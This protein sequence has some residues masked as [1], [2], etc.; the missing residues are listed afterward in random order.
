MDIYLCSR[1]SRREEM[2]EVRSTLR[3]L[4][5]RVTS[6]WLDTEWPHTEDGS[7]DAPEELRTVY[8]EQD[9]KDILLSDAL[10]AFT[11]GPRS[12][13]RGGRHVEFGLALAWRRRVYIVGPRE[14]VFH[15]MPGVQQFDTLEE[16]LKVLR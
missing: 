11:D 12:S 13:G 2:R 14:N 3:E 10:I 6:R 5:H 7:S 8:A 9:F 4:G 15:H 16:L 1:M